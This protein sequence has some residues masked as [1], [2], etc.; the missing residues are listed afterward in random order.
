MIGYLRGRR[1]SL[2]PELLVLDVGGV[3]YSV[4]IPLST[5]FELD[6]LEGGAEFGLH[7]HTHVRA[8]AIELFGFWT[9]AE[10]TLFEH[11]LGVSGVGPRLAQVVLSGGSTAD[12]LTAIAGGNVAALTRIPG[13]GRKTAE[14]MVLELKEKAKLL[15]AESGAEPPPA[16]TEPELEDD[17][18]QVI[19]ALL[20]LGY[21]P[22]EAR[23]AVSRVL[24]EHRDVEFQELL[25]Q[26]LRQLS[27]L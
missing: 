10:R 7:I 17:Q 25:R 16:E 20:N 21:R 26:S 2:G 3:G 27:R 23:R 19:S 22:N 6:K 4:R 8:D 1:Q 5:Y 15:L 14:R 18:E 9:E 24:T 11:C 13:I 12:L